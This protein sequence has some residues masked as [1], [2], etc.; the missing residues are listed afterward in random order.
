M[1]FLIFKITRSYPNFKMLLC[2]FLSKEY[3]SAVEEIYGYGN[4]FPFFYVFPMRLRFSVLM[5]GI[6]QY[7]TIILNCISK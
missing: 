4:V 1:F 7:H 6:D 2:L 3:S 5:D